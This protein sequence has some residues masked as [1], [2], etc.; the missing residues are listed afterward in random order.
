MDSETNSIDQPLVFKRILLT[1]D[2]DDQDSTAKAF[3]F[4]VTQAKVNQASLGIVSVMESDDLSVFDSLTPAKVDEKRD[5]LHEVVNDYINHAQADGVVDVKGYVAEDGDV[6]DIIVEDVIPR[7]NPDLIVC[8]ADSNP[9]RRG[10]KAAI[11]VQLSK[12]AP[13]SVIVVR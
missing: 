7:F 2:V 9:E 11:S 6:D 13:V 5:A 10:H 8:G 12:K 3:R 1:V 4:A